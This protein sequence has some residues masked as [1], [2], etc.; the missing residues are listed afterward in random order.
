MS[1]GSHTLAF[2]AGICVGVLVCGLFWLR[3]VLDQ[4]GGRER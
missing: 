1:I 2:F 3:Y 4:A